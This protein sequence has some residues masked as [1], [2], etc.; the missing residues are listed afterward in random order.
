MQAL[1]A[2]IRD[3]KLRRRFDEDE[4]EFEDGFA[5]DD[6]DDGEYEDADGDDDEFGDDDDDLEEEFD[7]D[8]EL[9]EEV[10]ER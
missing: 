5:F 7:D 10:E 2:S 3:V 8:F 1:V 6:S 4:E 9:D